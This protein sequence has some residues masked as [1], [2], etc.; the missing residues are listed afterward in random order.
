LPQ[1]YSD[2]LPEFSKYFQSPQLIVKSIYGTDAAA[3]VFNDDLVEWLTTNEHVRFMQSKIDP[4]L[5]VYRNGNEYCYLIVYID[6]CLN[7]ISSSELEEKFT[8]NLKKSF[9]LELQGHSHWFLG[10]RL[11]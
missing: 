1:E 10:S 7:K 9:D 8:S 5:F 11:Y 2:L 3:K 6:N 4:S